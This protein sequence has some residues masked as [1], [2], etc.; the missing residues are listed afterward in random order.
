M[1]RQTFEIEIITPCFCAGALPEHRAE[2]RVPSIRGQ[3]RWWFRVLGGFKNP[4]SEETIFGA[5]AGDEGT[6]GMLQLQ[7]QQPIASADRR[8]AEDLGGGMNSD[9]GYALFPLRPF[10][11]S[12]GKRG[13]MKEGTT[14]S[15]IVTWRGNSTNW[16]D[17]ASLV[18]VWANLGSLGFRSRRTM[19]ALMLRN[20]SLMLP[21]ALDALKNGIDV[22]SI[23]R[24]AGGTWRNVEGAWR[25]VA[26]DLLKWYR[27]WRQ[28]GRTQDLRPGNHAGMPP[29]NAGFAYA[30]RDHDIGY[31]L[32]SAAKQPAFRPALGLPIIQRTGNGTKNWEWNWNTQRRRAEGRFASP[33]LL[34]PHRDASENWH[35]LVIFVDAMKWP[36]NKQVF[37][38]GQPRTVSS[39][40]Y[41][42]MKNDCQLSPFPT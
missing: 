14:F 22:R 16:H 26:G 40:L 3:L 1:I 31:Q 39:D 36:A 35:A 38:N 7:I 10:G 24:N 32:P 4:I 30:K 12:D 19:G 5:A 33:I 15:L 9:L 23:P 11:G 34:R 21:A 2:I 29:E 20:A 27:G 42:A 25:E 17:I 8:N 28:H 18:T 13:V 37:L 41:D 6:S